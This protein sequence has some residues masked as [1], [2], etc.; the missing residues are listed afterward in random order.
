MWFLNI[1]HHIDIL[2]AKN[3]NTKFRF[4]R[5]ILDISAQ[6]LLNCFLELCPLY[7]PHLVFYN[8]M[9]RGI[10]RDVGKSSQKVVGRNDLLPLWIRQGYS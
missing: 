10:N 5:R 8:A 4:G 1:V 7:T 3:R 2:G 6:W 9:W